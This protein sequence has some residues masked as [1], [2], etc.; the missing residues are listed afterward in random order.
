[1]ESGQPVVW[2]V[3]F[4]LSLGPSPFT[5]AL[6]HRIIAMETDTS[7]AATPK[8]NKQWSRACLNFQLKLT[9]VSSLSLGFVACLHTSTTVHN[10]GL[11]DNQ[12][13]SVQLLDISARVGQSNFVDFVGVQPNLALSALEDGSGQALL[14]F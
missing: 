14:Q 11:L 3:N 6:H 10:G 12:T 9:S 7:I 13:I 8:G 4:I 2:P 1:M 5:L